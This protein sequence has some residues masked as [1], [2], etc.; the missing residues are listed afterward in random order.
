[1]SYQEVYRRS[2]DDPQGYWAEQAAELHWFTPWEKVLD[3]SNA[4]FYRW[5]VG[6]ETNL[7]YNAVDRHALGP[8]RG[9]AAIIWESAETGL[10]RTLTYFEL[11]REVNR[12]A[13][14]MHNLGLR[15]GDRVL[16]YMPMVPEAII[17]MLA[18]ARLGAIHSVVFGGFSV[19]SLATRIDDA[20]PTLV[21]TADAGMRKG[22]PVPLKEML[23]ASLELVT[24]DSVRHVLVLNRNLVDIAMT[25]GRDLDWHET[26]AEH[27]VRYVEPTRVASTDP[28]YILYTS[29]TTGKPKGVVRDTG[30]YMVAL[31]ASMSQIYNVGEGDVYWS[32][33]DIGWVVG[34]SYIVY[35]PLLKGVPTVVYEGRPDHP[36]PGVWWRVIEK[37]G[38]T[39]VFT[40]P[41]ALRALR[42]FPDKWMHGSDISSLKTLFAA[43]EPLDEPTYQWASHELGVP[44]IDHYWQTE[45]GWSMLTN[46]IGVEHMAVKPG[47]P[48]KPAFGH[49]LEVVDADGNRVPLGEKGFLVDHGPLPPGMLLTIWG[50]DE[51]YIQSYWS[52]FKNKLLYMSGDYA[53]EDKDGYFWMLGRADEVLNVS[54]HR[55][56]TREIE[57]VLS[58]H[59]A[60]AEVAVIGVKDELKGEGVLVVAV[61][62]QDIA[63]ITQTRVAEEMRQLVRDKIGA[64]ATPN[65]IQFVSMLPKTRSGKIMRR[66]IRAVYQG[67]N[68]GDLSTIED[69][70]TLDMVR[71]AVDVLTQEM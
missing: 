42:K 50:D 59:P 33:S 54:G 32:T 47:S 68:I 53:I 65:A 9:Q 16:I 18:C 70:A 37:Y 12:L 25:H 7:C 30:G 51:R 10:S 38:V 13:G 19:Q 11:Y 23:D 4:P 49:R 64:I 43:G 35:G 24:T 58:G 17:G 21:L 57:E 55:L 27:N 3:D 34:H 61:L 48:T 6:G 62:K 44:V 14:A 39:C 41:T 52:H 29:G 67:D 15:K 63:P 69:D 36:D 20:T 31:H 56:G 22:N 71:E 1:M 8:K 2:I 28:S 46:P 40:A 5:F 26:L 60:A 66:V 45:S